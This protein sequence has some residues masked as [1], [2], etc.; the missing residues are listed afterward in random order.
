MPSQRL[1]DEER[2]TCGAILQ[3]MK[4]RT[5]PTRMLLGTAGGLLAGGWLVGMT[6]GCWQER[7]HIAKPV[8]MSASVLVSTAAVIGALRQPDRVPRLAAM[9]MLCGTAGDLLLAE[10]VP[11]PAP[12]LLAGMLAFGIGHVCYLRSASLHIREQRLPRR[13]T[14]GGLSLGWL[15]AASGWR[16]LAY[17][18]QHDPAFKAATLAY[19]LLLGSLAGVGGALAVADRRLLRLGVGGLLFLFSDLVLAAGQFRGL[20]FPGSNDLVWLTYL[21]AQILIVDALTAPAA[22]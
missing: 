13:L 10:V 12:P 16:A 3:A 18:P 2:G 11:T 7:D 9:G 21:P 5:T 15:T 8:R 19:A 1:T 4:K 17:Q 6:R 20:E 22:Q 14:W